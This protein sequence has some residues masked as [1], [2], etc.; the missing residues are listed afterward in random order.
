MK[1]V[2]SGT[3][4]LSRDARR[5]ELMRNPTATSDDVYK[6]IKRYPFIFPTGTLEIYS[7]SNFWL[8][9]LVIEKASGMTYE[10]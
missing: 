10:D 9:G 7:N 3:L 5:A 1:T 4:R 6:V 8:L 2:L